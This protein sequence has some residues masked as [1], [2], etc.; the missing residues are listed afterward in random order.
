MQCR[1]NFYTPAC[2]RLGCHS[3]PADLYIW[4]KRFCRWRDFSSATQ[5]PQKVGRKSLIYTLSVKRTRSLVVNFL[6]RTNGQKPVAE[7]L[8]STEAAESCLDGRL[9]AAFSRE[10]QKPGAWTR[11]CLHFTTSYSIHPSESIHLK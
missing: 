4:S 9:G 10:S 8:H 5:C 11:Y 2:D 1:N 3:S 7:S 6:I